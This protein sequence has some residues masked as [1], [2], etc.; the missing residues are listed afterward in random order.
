MVEN[1]ELSFEDT[2]EEFMPHLFGVGRF[3]APDGLDMHNGRPTGNVLLVR[4]LGTTPFYLGRACGDIV[5]A[6]SVGDPYLQ[7]L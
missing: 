4:Y 2:G 1:S 7:C 5:F 6:A 3:L